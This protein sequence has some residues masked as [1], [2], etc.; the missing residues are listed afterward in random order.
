[1]EML[2]EEIIYNIFQFLSMSE[3][4]KLRLNVQFD[5]ICRDIAKKRAISLPVYIS[6]MINIFSYDIV[7]KN[8]F[9]KIK[10]LVRSDI[11]IKVYLNFITIS[12][13]KFVWL[14][15][16][17]ESTIEGVFCLF[18]ELHVISQNKYRKNFY[19]ILYELKIETVHH[20]QSKNNST[21]IIARTDQRRFNFNFKPKIMKYD[22][23]NQI[24]EKEMIVFPKS[25]KVVDSLA[26]QLKLLTA[27][28]SLACK[29]NYIPEAKHIKFE[30]TINTKY[31]SKFAQELIF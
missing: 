27:L 24:I 15:F 11:N 13:E 20:I 26:N 5:R 22:I 21:S 25:V 19:K 6:N 7:Y 1:M 2:P 29:Y 23:T 9:L 14:S 28:S 18:P 3:L 31:I 10:E 17:C 4:R 8:I 30:D 12:K 16:L